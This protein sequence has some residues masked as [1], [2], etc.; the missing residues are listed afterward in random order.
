MALALT[1][2]LLVVAV[3]LVVGL[4]GYLINRLNRS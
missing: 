4:I 3:V 2:S 1:V